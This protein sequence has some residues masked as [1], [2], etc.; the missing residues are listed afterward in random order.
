MVLASRS[1]VPAALLLISL[2][3][4]FATGLR[5]ARNLPA[6]VGDIYSARRI[7]ETRNHSLYSVNETFNSI[8]AVNT[9]NHT[10]LYH[11]LLNLWARFVGRDL[12]TLRV[13]SVCLGLLAISSTYR[14]AHLCGRA[15][16]LDTALLLSFLAFFLFYTQIAR[17]YALLILLAPWLLFSYW[18]AL[19]AAAKNLG[20]AWLS[21]AVSASAIVYTHL[22]GAFVIAAIGIYH[23]I[24][25]P[26]NRRW[27]T[28]ALGLGASAILFLPWLP[29]VLD[30]LT[31]W[32]VT[33]DSGLPIFDALV[34]TLSVYSNG[35]LPLIP[36]VALII[37]RRFRTLTKAQH[38]IVV[39]SCVVLALMLAANE[40]TTVILARRMRYTL[41]LASVWS[42]AL[43]VGLNFL[44]HWRA[45]R[46]P[47]LLC[48][49]AA[50]FAFSGSNNMRLYNNSHDL[51]HGDVPNYQFLIYEPTISPRSSDFV[52]SFHQDSPYRSK[53]TLHYYGNMT[54]SWRGLIQF[55]NSD[56]ED[57][58]VLSNDPRYN[59]IHSLADW[60]FPI[61]AIHNPQRTDL[62][63]MPAYVSEFAPRFHSCGRH[64]DAP[65]TV[66]DLYVK[67][68]IPC[69]LLT[70]EQ[71]LR[72][73]Y[74]RGTELENILLDL[75]ADELSVFFW[76]T[77]TF[78]NEYS[79]SIQIFDADGLKALQVDDVIGGSALVRQSV[80]ISNLPAG[81]F[82]VQLIVYDYE[83][84]ASQSGIFL[85]D[86]R[87]FKRAVEVGRI[88]TSH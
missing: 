40:I 56:A 85:A 23:L 61:W 24:F 9:G 83:T 43:A 81:E 77:K 74:D 84:G 69:D 57:V 59:D 13:L 10:P 42:V 27:A 54:G 12:F 5:N 73:L 52:L 34:A 26:K 44:P 11:I 3:F 45:L 22:F 41:I 63:A 2:T 76:W 37:A 39:V 67:R 21:L 19:H 60:N 32:N 71:P 50:Y 66:V 4:V 53:H 58:G 1:L 46:I 6:T 75:E 72:V 68:S 79:Y 14:L 78:A 51:R 17:F 86:G 38:Y 20:S 36:F 48:W 25:V 31:M 88:L 82:S 35:L 70:T 15:E 28:V 80:D 16:A 87:P 7:Y 47:A 55:W 49:I 18:R 33:E 30:G 8:V 29:I 62:Q 65:D 64:I